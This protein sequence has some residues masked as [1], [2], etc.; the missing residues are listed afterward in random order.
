[1]PKCDRNKC[2]YSFKIS[3][4]LTNSQLAKK[5]RQTKIRFKALPMHIN[6]LQTTSRSI[7]HGACISIRNALNMIK[8]CRHLNCRK[9]YSDPG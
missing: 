2:S 3:E 4:L 7:V 5:K 6:Q 1:M 8:L 9:I